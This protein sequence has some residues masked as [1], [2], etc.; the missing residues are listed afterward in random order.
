[1]K[2]S[3]LLVGSFL[4]LSLGIGITGLAGTVFINENISEIVD[5]ELPKVKNIVDMKNAISSADS[6][7]SEFLRLGRDASRQGFQANMDRFELILRHNMD[8]VNTPEEE[9]LLGQLSALLATYRDAAGRLAAAHESQA[10]MID[11]RDRLLGGRIEPALRDMLQRGLDPL[12]PGYAA[13]WLALKELEV[14]SQELVSASRGYRLTADPVLK[15]A[16]H[17]NIRYF[18]QLLAALQPTTGS[19]SV[20]EARQQEMLQQVAGDFA[21]VKDLSLRMLELEDEK[22]RLLAEFQ[23]TSA[24]IHSILDGQLEP[25]AIAGARQDA[26]GA[27]SAT[28]ITSAALAMAIVF[29]VMLGVLLSRYITKPLKA[30][31][32]A[33][34][35]I[36]KG[37]LDR[38]VSIKGTGE[39][40]QLSRSFNAMAEKLKIHDAMQRE[41]ISVASH[42]LRNPIQPILNYA[43]LAKK[44]L[45]PTDEALDV[46]MEEAGRLSFL[47]NNILDVSRIESGQLVYRMEKFFINNDIFS[48]IES[49]KSVLK[50][51]VAIETDLAPC[52][53]IEGDRGRISQVITNVLLNAARYTDKGRILVQSRV[54]VPNPGGSA[55]VQPTLAIKVSDTGRGIPE[56][57]LPNVFDKFVTTSS[58]E[59]FKE[60]TGLGLYISKAIVEAH[61]GRMAAYNNE[62]GGATFEISLP[63]SQAPASPQ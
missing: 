23:G 2:L 48:A 30:L 38:R 26:Q 1:M 3:V 16:V 49:A 61:G 11:E 34:S 59:G 12:D 21:S 56:D 8:L 55:N 18:E 31:E 17:S 43:D 52:E 42:E 25:L 33:A 44:G 32:G 19:P 10:A 36:A 62:Q 5:R 50:D 13:K 20:E 40:A 35:S 47:A 41:F 46:V 53:K 22:Q 63:F 4:V 39:L 29:A 24:G 54:V 60:G 58:L 28:S 57:I 6:D 45:I 37:N 27:A 14:T 51:G 15:G 7:M 9:L